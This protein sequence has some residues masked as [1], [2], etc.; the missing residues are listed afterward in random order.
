MDRNSSPADADDAP[1]DPDSDPG[2]DRDGPPSRD[3]SATAS[4]GDGETGEESAVERSV[5]TG[6]H[7]LGPD[8]LFDALAHSTNRYVL[9]YLIK[10]ERTVSVDELVEYVVTAVDRPPEMESDGEFRGPVRA[11]V[12]RSVGRL[13]S[14]GFLVYDG[15]T[16]TVAPTERTA[17][18]EPYL[19]LA[20]EQLS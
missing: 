2:P 5:E 14:L 1:A 7:S 15:T 16:K 8:D 17:V 20:L 6:R 13:E 3:A 4:D 11:T 10:S 12:E 19:A 9:Y 18:A